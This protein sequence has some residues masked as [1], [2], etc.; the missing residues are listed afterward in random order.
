MEEILQGR[1]ALFQGRIERPALVTA[2]MNLEAIML[3]EVNQ[4]QKEELTHLWN[5]KEKKKRKKKVE[6]IETE[7][8]GDCQGLEGGG[9]F[10]SKGANL[11]TSDGSGV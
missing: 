10:W 3:R 5:E 8:N 1:S 6:F 7:K 9:S 4:A 11:Q 2:W